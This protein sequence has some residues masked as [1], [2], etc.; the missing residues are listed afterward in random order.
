MPGSKAAELTSELQAREHCPWLYFTWN[1]SV[2]RIWT[3]ESWL[4]VR[5]TRERRIANHS[6]N[7]KCVNKN[8]VSRVPQGRGAFKLFE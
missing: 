7:T 6:E 4:Q 2:E 1:V 5:H 8:A 3:Q